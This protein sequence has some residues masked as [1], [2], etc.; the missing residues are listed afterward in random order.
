MKSATNNQLLSAILIV[1]SFQ[2][3]MTA[4]LVGAVAFHP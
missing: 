4:V 3:F 1:A 2:L